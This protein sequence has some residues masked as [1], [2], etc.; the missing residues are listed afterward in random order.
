MKPRIH[1]TYTLPT[2]QYTLEAASRNLII[3]FVVSIHGIHGL[4]IYEGVRERVGQGTWA[5][6]QITMGP[7]YGG[8]TIRTVLLAMRVHHYGSRCIIIAVMGYFLF[9]YWCLTYVR[10]EY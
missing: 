5:R 10:T 9:V 3:T 4:D 1:T 2:L 7:S 8:Q 6:S